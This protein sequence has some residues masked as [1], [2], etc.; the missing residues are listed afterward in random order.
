MTEQIN[1]PFCGNLIDRNAIK[2]KNCDAL[3]KEPELPN[4]KFKE[5]APFLVIDILLYNIFLNIS[6]VFII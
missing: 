5:L 1:C 3:F 4:I 6:I 2:C